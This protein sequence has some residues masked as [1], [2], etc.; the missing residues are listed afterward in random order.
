MALPLVY[1]ISSSLKPLNELWLFPPTF[2]VRNPTFKN[3]KDLFS[4]MSDSWVPFSR[5]LFN[6]VFITVVG[7]VGHIILSSMC[8]FSICKL[9]F[10]GHQ[11]IFKIIVL[12]LMFSTAVTSIPS[13]LVINLFGLVDTYPAIL[14]PAFASSL[15][16]YLMKQFMES[17]VPDALIEAARIDGASNLYLYSKIVM[18]IVKPAWLTLI[19]FSFQNLWNVGSTSVI[20]SEELKTLN[21][22]ISQIVSG[23]IARAGTASAATVVMMLVPITVF[24]ITQ[25]NVV[26]T[27]ATS[28]MKE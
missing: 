18:P 28:G 9:K 27:M 15:G 3:F 24:L 21:Y 6:T 11:V 5:Y 16:L 22:A 20:Q 1:S 2:F 14:L 13:F 23:G 26:E 4:L 25:S 17:M 7:T 10:K 8:A 19:L 12:S